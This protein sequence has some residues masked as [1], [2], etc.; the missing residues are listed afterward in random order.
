MWAAHQ[1]T[2]HNLARHRWKAGSNFFIGGPNPILWLLVLFF[3]FAA[4]KRNKI[5]PKDC[6]GTCL[7]GNVRVDIVIQRV[8]NL[9]VLH[10]ACKAIRTKLRLFL[11]LRLVPPQE[12]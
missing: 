10:N 9:Q 2:A 5:N 7:C 4:G 12:L 1:P 11:K 8:Y 3:G 6:S